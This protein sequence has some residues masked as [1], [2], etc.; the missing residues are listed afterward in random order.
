MFVLSCEADFWDLTFTDVN[1]NGDWKINLP[2]EYETK[3]THVEWLNVTNTTIYIYR[4]TKLFGEN[5]KRNYKIDATFC[6]EVWKM[7]RKL[8]KGLNFLLPS[9]Q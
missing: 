6:T 7:V 8:D 4:K 1:N 2:A 3:I 9:Q 5:S